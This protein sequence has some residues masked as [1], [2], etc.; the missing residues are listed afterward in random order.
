MPKTSGSFKKGHPGV[1][2]KGALN[3]TTKDIKE[4]YRLLIEKNLDNLTGWLETIA[5]K[6]PEKAIRILND[7]SEYVIPKLART[8]LT[9]DLNHDIK[10]TIIFKKFNK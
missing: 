10:T 5:E 3:K 2:P 9:G 6:D 7:L 8:D 1:K 4:A